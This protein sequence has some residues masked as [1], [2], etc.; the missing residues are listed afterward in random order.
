MTVEK[1]RILGG[2]VFKLAGVFEDPI[3]AIEL[4]KELK[5]DKQVFLH[6]SESGVWAVYWRNKEDTPECPSK[7]YSI[8]QDNSGRSIIDTPSNQEL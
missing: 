6:R 2:R 5:Q 3:E 8:A 4:A 7:L 1:W